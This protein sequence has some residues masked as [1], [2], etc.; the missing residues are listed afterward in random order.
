MDH[1][2]DHAHS[3]MSMD[4]ED[5]SA[6]NSMILAIRTPTSLL[7]AEWCIST[8]HGLVIAII[9]SAVI[10]ICIEGFQE[11]RSVR[12]LKAAARGPTE[13]LCGPDTI[14]IG[15]KLSCTLA[16]VCQIGISYYLMLSVMTGN[17]WIF[18]AIIT[19]SGI[20][21]FMLRPVI[22]HFYLG[23]NSKPAKD[24]SNGDLVEKKANLTEVTS[25]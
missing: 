18:L 15:C 3:S 20:G 13:G 4:H 21:Y 7:F 19:G 5:H 23:G 17:V 1:E 24:N 11:Y 12:V 9:L 10:S 2:N 16:Y 22:R 25:L 6:I 14:P 8:L